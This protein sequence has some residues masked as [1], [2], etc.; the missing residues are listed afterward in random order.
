MT[1]ADGR[2]GQRL[3]VTGFADDMVRLLA[4]RFGLGE[5]AVVVPRVRIPGGGPMVVSVGGQRLGLGID[6]CHAVTV[7]PR[8]QQV[9]PHDDRPGR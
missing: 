9:M 3:V 2:V 1:L 4:I 6:I 5:G 8:G 7:M